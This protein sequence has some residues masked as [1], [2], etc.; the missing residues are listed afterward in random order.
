MTWSDELD[1][2]SKAYQIASSKAEKICLIAGPGTGKSYSMNKRIER[3]LEDGVNPEK[4]LAVTFTNVAA[5]DMHQELVNMPVTGANRLKA[6]T[7]HSLAFGILSKNHVLTTTGRVPRPLLKFEL[8]PLKADLSAH[9]GKTKIK[10]MIKAFGADWLNLVGAHID[11]VSDEELTGFERDLKFWLIFHHSMLLDEI[12]PKTRN[13]LKRNP[14]AEERCK[15]KHILVDEYQDLNKAEQ[16]LLTFLADNAHVCIIGD[17][18]QSIYSFKHAHPSGI[19]DWMESNPSHKLFSIDDCYRCPTSVVSIANSLIGKNTDRLDKQLKPMSEKG[20]GVVNICQYHSL[21]QEIDG[22]ATFVKQCIDSDVPA[23][24]ILVLAQRRQIA[25]PIY[26]K[27]SEAGVSVKSYYGELALKNLRAKEK[28]ALLTLLSDKEDRVSLRWLLGFSSSSWYSGTYKKLRK[29]CDENDK[30]PFQVLDEQRQGTVTV[31]GIRKLSERFNE[32][33]TEL[34]ELG[35]IQGVGEQI[36]K[37]FPKGEEGLEQIRRDALD[38]LE[39]NENCS[40]KNVHDKLRTVISRPEETEEDDDDD[41]VRIMSLHKSKGLSSPI[42]IIV[43]CV[44]G[45]LPKRPDAS[46]PS[47]EQQLLLQ[48]QRRLFYVGMT[49][50]KANLSEGKKGVL[51]ITSSKSM[52][53]SNALQSG[54][55]FRNTRGSNAILQGSRFLSE[56]GE[57]APAP[58]IGITITPEDILN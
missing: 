17:D 3:L 15:F 34:D 44:E 25:T 41:S 56:L 45:L 55:T 5:N 6:R 52:P 50:V 1:P 11:E 19:Q 31:S 49:R 30:S 58:K 36:D 9:G 27:L 22:V 4:I 39:K 8:E 47:R 21:A 2:S 32:I 54:I 57:S 24:D 43:G 16:D 40:L 23:G 14:A 10:E 48:E 37:L 42:T 53:T 38:F 26:E 35:A 12:I 7:L 29:Y 51:V 33:I 13:Y 28:F 20:E 18:D 46:L